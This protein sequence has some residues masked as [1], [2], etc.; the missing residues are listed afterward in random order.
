MLKVNNKADS[1]EIFVNGTIIDDEE[2]G[3]IKFWDDDTAG[4]QWPKDIKEQLDS[5]KGKPLTVYINS[6]GGAV[7]AGLAMAHMIERHDAPTTAIIDGYCCSIATQIFFS[8]D[9]C[10]MPSNSYLMLHKPSTIEAGNA[11]DFRKAADILD[12]I[13]K[14]LETTY[15]NK[16]LESTTVE[17][18]S[19]MVNQETWL[20]G[21]DAAKL[22]K[23]ELM[24]PLKT[25]NCMGSLD[26]L[27]AMNYQKIPEA[28]KFKDDGNKTP[29][30]F[31]IEQQQ[32]LQD[33]QNKKIRIALTRA[34]STMI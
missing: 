14:G 22:F 3:W 4:Y 7:G 30:S 32:K 31:L 27:K 28:L 2:S 17:Q 1:A 20:T 5:V 11:D 24:E 16:A 25:V 29:P 23:V 12:V 8:A 15:Q 18:I 34:K 21:A 26:K 6:Y 13:Q 33:E 19:E 9:V 10:K